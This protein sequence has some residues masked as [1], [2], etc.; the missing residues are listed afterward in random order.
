MLRLLVVIFTRYFRSRRDLVLE[1]VALR[2]QLG[3]LMLKHPQPRFAATDKLFWVILR[4]PW[5]GWE[6]A[7]ILFQ[8]ETVIRWDRAV[9]LAKTLSDREIAMS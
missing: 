6:R 7:L 5:P 1:N 2:Q 8:P 4:R 3:V 9:C